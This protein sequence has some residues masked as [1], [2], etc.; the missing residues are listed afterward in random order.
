MSITRM[1][2]EKNRVTSVLLFVVLVAG[3]NMYRNMPRNEDP[4]FIIRMSSASS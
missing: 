2:I 4:G 3:L 1:A